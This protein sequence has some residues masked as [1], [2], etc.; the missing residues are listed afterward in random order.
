MPSKKLLFESLSQNHPFLD[1]NKRTAVTAAVGF[2]LLNGLYESGPGEQSYDRAMAAA[3]CRASL[4]GYY[5]PSTPTI[6]FSSTARQ[7]LAGVMT[8]L[9][10]IT[11]PFSVPWR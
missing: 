5:H 1:G 3:A 7:L 8:M 6:R 11:W 10:N 9:R 2:L 4:T